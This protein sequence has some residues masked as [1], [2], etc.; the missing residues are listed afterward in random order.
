MIHCSYWYRYLII[1]N[2]KSDLK[3]DIF[4]FPSLEVL[5]LIDTCTLVPG[6]G[7]G[8]WNKRRG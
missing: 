1:G 7:V 2:K 6:R 3:N 5:D 4:K 8:W